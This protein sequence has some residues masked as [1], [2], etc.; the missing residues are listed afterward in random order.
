M[1]GLVLQLLALTFVHLHGNQSFCM[2]RVASAFPEAFKV[3]SGNAVESASFPWR[4]SKVTLRLQSPVLRSF[5][6]WPLKAGY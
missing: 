1:G 6:Y 3:F 2:A 4:C 5:A